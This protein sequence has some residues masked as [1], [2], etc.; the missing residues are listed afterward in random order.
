MVYK[1]MALQKII[2]FYT[3]ISRQRRIQKLREGK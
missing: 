3:Q 2:E 1:S